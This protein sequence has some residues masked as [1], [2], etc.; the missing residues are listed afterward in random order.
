M[1]K[2]KTSEMSWISRLGGEKKFV[3]PTEFGGGVIKTA[4]TVNHKKTIV[5]SLLV[6]CRVEGR[7]EGVYVEET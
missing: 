1:V 2:E 4:S 5:V 7:D 3:H 6:L